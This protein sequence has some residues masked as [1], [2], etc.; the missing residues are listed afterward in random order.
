MKMVIFNAKLKE[1]Y[2]I[3]NESCYVRTGT[4]EEKEKSTLLFVFLDSIY[5]TLRMQQC[6]PLMF[7]LS[8]RSTLRSSGF[9]CKQVIRG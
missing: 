1:L 2:R 8:F 7:L 6:L 5:W 3:E 4:S 9:M